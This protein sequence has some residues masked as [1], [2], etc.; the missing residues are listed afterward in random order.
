MP[1][2]GWTLPV[3]VASIVGV[4]GQDYKRPPRMFIVATVATSPFD[5]MFRQFLVCENSAHYDR[6]D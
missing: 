3:A 2:S 5:T 1:T 4:F 6:G